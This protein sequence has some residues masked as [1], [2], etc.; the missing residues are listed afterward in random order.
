MEILFIIFRTAFL[1]GLVLLPALMLLDPQMSF[2]GGIL[3][4]LGVDILTRMFTSG[5]KPRRK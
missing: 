5:A 2:F 4:I 3:L 1:A